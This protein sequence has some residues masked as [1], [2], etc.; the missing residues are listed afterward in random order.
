M[1]PALASRTTTVA[2]TKPLQ[3]DFIVMSWIKPAVVLRAL[4]QGYVVLSA[5]KASLLPH[6][7]AGTSCRAG[8]LPRQPFPC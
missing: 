4:R 6:C 7:R 8:T 5:G 1:H 3:H 2:S